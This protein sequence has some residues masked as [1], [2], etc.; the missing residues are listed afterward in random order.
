[1]SGDAE[2][3]DGAMPIGVITAIYSLAANGE[4]IV[5][6]NRPGFDIIPAVVQL[7]IVALIHE[8]VMHDPAGDDSE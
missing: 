3:P 2:L 1:M 6:V 4:P 5:T 7:G 8:D